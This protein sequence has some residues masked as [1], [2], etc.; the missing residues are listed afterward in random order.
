MEISIQEI[1]KIEHRWKQLGNRGFGALSSLYNSQLTGDL[2]AQQSHSVELVD[3]INR[4]NGE[5]S[6]LVLHYD[7]LKSS[8]ALVSSN[9][10][11]SVTALVLLARDEHYLKSFESEMML[12]A[13][14]A[15]QF[16]SSDGNSQKVSFADELDTNVRFTA[17]LSRWNFETVN[18]W[19]L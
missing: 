6:K 10:K 2:S 18:F 17:L 11:E 13:Q 4:M 1:A 14:I 16:L 7:K 8:L 3:V 5:Y 12:K 9:A 19:F 15:H